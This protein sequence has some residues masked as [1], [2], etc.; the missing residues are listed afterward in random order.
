MHERKSISLDEI[1]NVHEYRI[2]VCPNCG[3]DLLEAEQA[4]RTTQQIEVKTNTVHIDQ[5]QGNAFWCPKCRKVHY[6]PIPSEVK[7]AAWLARG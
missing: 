1:D 7:K 3:E 2:V 6:E 4:P 5:H